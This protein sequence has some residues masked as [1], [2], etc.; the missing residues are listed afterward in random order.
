MLPPRCE[1]QEYEEM[2]YQEPLCQPQPT[3]EISSWGIGNN[4]ITDLKQGNYDEEKMRNEFRD[5]LK[6]WRGQEV[7]DEREEYPNEEEGWGVVTSQA[8][9]RMPVADMQI[10]TDD[11][12]KPQ[13]V[14]TTIQHRG[15][16]INGEWEGQNDDT[17]NLIFKTSQLSLS[18]SENYGPLPQNKI[19][20]T[21][22]KAH[23]KVSC[24]NCYKLGDDREFIYDD[25]LVNN[26]FCNQKC[27]ELYHSKYALVCPVDNK[28]F[29]KNN[30]TL[31]LWIWY[32]SDYWADN[33][34]PK[35]V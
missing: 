7:I 32:W 12:L 8:I 9:P 1:Q 13:M 25:S 14:T 35:I 26:Y 4:E 18:S 34:E 17:H 10:G 31:A 28:L 27:S 20:A 3:Q 6:S 21:T 19:K 30:G 29:L 5:A 22:F 33:G 2:P 11:R 15:G 16:D 23:K 24:Y